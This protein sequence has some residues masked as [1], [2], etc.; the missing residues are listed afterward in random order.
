MACVPVTISRTSPSHSSTHH[1]VWCTFGTKQPQE[2]SSRGEC[3]LPWCCRHIRQIRHETYRNQR[4]V[5]K[6]QMKNSQPCIIQH[7][8]TIHRITHMHTHTQSRTHI[9]A[10]THTHTNTHTHTPCSATPCP[11]GCSWQQDHD[12]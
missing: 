3:V 9:P 2:L 11:V 10:H 8:L 1:S 7:C 4:S 12:G 5:Y 6:K